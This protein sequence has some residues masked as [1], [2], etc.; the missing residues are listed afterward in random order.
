[1]VVLGPPLLF[2]FFMLYG[3]VVADALQTEYR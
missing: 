1:M 2:N 3:Y